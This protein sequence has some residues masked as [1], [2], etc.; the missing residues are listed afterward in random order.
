ML[1]HTKVE[2]E[3]LNDINMVMFVEGA[4]RGGV[5]FTANRFEQS[6]P[7]LHLAYLDAT[8]LVIYYKCP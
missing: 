5:S 6:G 4:I 7:N 3:L 1:R 2:L 8:N